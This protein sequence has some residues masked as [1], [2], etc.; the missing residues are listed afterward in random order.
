MNE[1]FKKAV[2]DHNLTKVRISLTNELLLD[3]RGATFRDMLTYAITN[4]P[5]L[6]EE[7]KEADYTVPPIDEWNEDFI[8]KVKNDLDYNFSKEKLAFYEEVVKTVGK[9]KAEHIEKEERS[10][11]K[12]ENPDNNKDDKSEHSFNKTCAIVTAGGAT[13]TIIGLAAGKTLL[14]VVGG[15][16]LVVG[17]VLLLTHN[18][19]KK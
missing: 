19:D 9:G 11:K 8:F 17:G 5:D 6:F 10:S 16:A 15:T 7:N 3:P 2:A 1:D 18:L 12:Q 13:L 4:I 14:S